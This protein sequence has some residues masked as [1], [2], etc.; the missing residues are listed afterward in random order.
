[1]S[2]Q[3]QRRTGHLAELKHLHAA[4]ARAHPQDVAPVFSVVQVVVGRRDS[5][6][7]TLHARG[8]SAHH[9]ETRPS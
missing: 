2:K 5:L 6:R 3:Q 9:E 8:V 7:R 4:H 1:M